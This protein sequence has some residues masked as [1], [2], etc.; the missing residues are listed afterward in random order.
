MINFKERRARHGGKVAPS[1][2]IIWSRVLEM[3]CGKNNSFLNE[4][5]YG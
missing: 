3:L 5:D 4:C 2:H 1:V